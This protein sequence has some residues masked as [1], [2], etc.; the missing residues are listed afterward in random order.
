VHLRGEEFIQA[1]T[2]YSKSQ[3]KLLKAQQDVLRQ[4][5]VI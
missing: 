5:R 2:L 4:L 1:L 3:G